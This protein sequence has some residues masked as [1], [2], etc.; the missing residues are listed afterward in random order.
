M[1][2]E[3]L[4]LHQNPRVSAECN[5]HVTLNCEVA[6]PREGLS[7]K[8]MEWSLNGTSLCTV[9]KKGVLTTHPVHTVGVFHCDYIH[10]QLSLV[11][12]K[13]RPRGAVNSKYTCKMHCNHGVEY[14]NTAVELRGQSQLSSFFFSGVS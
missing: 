9:D 2:T 8:R 10:G 14:M 5:K 11:L 3:L 6:S 13:V 1:C 12:R 7:I 4:K